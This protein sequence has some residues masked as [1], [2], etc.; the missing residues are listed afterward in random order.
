MPEWTLPT[1]VK[2]DEPI[3]AYRRLRMLHCIVCQLT[4][5]LTDY[6]IYIV[7]S[8]PKLAKCIKDVIRNV[9]YVGLRFELC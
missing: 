8:L 4:E 1:L 5:G 6:S 2:L 7:G 3:A 9:V